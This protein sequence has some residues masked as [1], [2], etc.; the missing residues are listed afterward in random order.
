MLDE[1][2]SNDDYRR[3]RELGAMLEEAVPGLRRL[4]V[5]QPYTQDPKWG[6]LDAAIDIWCPLFGF[7]DEPSIKRVL[8]EGDEVWSYTALIQNAPPYHPDYQSVKNE[9]PPYWEIDFPLTSYRVSTW[10]NRRYDITGLLYWTTIQ[11]ASDKRN[12]WDDPG[13][14]GSFNGGGQF[15][16]PGEEAGI[17]GPVSSIRLKVLRDAMEDYE[18]FVIL[19]QKGKKELVKEI[20][21]EV[22]PDWGSWKQN[23]EVYIEM[24][25]KMGEVISSA[26]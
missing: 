25:K 3:V 18:Y 2:N 14:R 21:N 20:V 16:Y 22:V 11:W 1:P 10:L 19:E 12:P 26:N 23:P 4:V 15:I 5:E 13:F 24:R 8:Q 6:S 9:D 7:I 17:N